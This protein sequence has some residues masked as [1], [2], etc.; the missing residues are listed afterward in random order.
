M[1]FIH[2]DLE[3]LKKNIYVKA[4]MTNKINMDVFSESLNIIKQV[5]M[6]PKKKK[7][8]MIYDK[9]IAP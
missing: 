1:M 6:T 3:I 4:A 9:N 8:E 5:P 2:N 7:A